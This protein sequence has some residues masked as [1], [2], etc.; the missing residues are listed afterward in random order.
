LRPFSEQLLDKSRV[1]AFFHKGLQLG[2]FHRQK[3]RNSID[4]EYSFSPD[5][6][7]DALAETGV[8]FLELKSAFLQFLS[9][10]GSLLTLFHIQQEAKTPKMKTT[11]MLILVNFDIFHFDIEKFFVNGVDF[12]EFN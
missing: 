7:K 10:Y 12:R 4:S 6:S 11:I 9:F 2:I 3:P 8:F 1:V 5:A